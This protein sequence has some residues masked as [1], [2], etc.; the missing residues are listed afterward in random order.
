MSQ[1]NFPCCLLSLI[2]EV[3][4]CIS[5]MSL[6]ALYRSVLS[7]DVCRRGPCCACYP[8]CLCDQMTS[9][10]IELATGNLDTVLAFCERCEEAKRQEQVVSL[11]LQ[12]TKV[13][14]D[15]IL[16]HIMSKFTYVTYEV[17]DW[18]VNRIEHINW[19]W[20]QCREVAEHLPLPFNLAYCCLPPL[21]R[22]LLFERHP[23][24]RPYS[25]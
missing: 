13:I 22:G 6:R 10:E 5:F 3:N 11:Q 9:Q 23:Q 21:N 16:S 20:V 14:Q 19:H 1:L 8:G 2:L 15:C 4:R 24:L 25:R 18:G 17:D 12:C 7:P